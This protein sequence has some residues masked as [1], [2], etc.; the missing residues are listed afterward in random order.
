MVD[1]LPAG[2]YWQAAGIGRFQW[3]MTALGVVMGGHVRTG[4]EDNLYLDDEKHAAA[5]N[6]ALV[7]RLAGLARA[8]G[9]ALATRAEA[10]QLMGLGAARDTR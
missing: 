9:R 2:T 5:T 7:A 10:R 8:A 4:L 3:P 1:R 6:E